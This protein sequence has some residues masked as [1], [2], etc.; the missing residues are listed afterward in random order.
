MP[1]SE[2]DFAIMC[3]G[4]NFRSDR[5]ECIRKLRNIENVNLQLLIVDEREKSESGRLHEKFSSLS[6][7]WINTSTKDAINKVAWYLQQ[8]FSGSPF[9]SV[10]LSDELN[11][12]KQIECGV[13]EDGFSEYFFKDDVDEIKSHN[14][15]FILRFG[16]GI[17]RGEILKVPNYGVWS[18]HHGDERKY[19]GGP[20]CFWEIYNDDPVTG[21]ILQRLTDRLDGGIIL[22]RGFFA[23][24]SSYANNKE[25]VNFGTTEWPAQVAIDILNGQAGYVNDPPTNSDAPI[26]RSPSPSQI[27]LY[28]LKRWKSL[29]AS[30]LSGINHWNIGIIQGCISNSLDGD[31]APE[32][33]WY[34]YPKNDGFLAD[35]FPI[36]IG[37]N[38][39]IFFEDYSYISKKGKISYIKYPEGF[40]KGNLKTA[41]EEPFHLSYPYL[42]KQDSVIYATPDNGD[43]KVVLY[44]VKKPSYWKKEKVLLEDDK[45]IS[46]PTIINYNST[47]WLFCTKHPYNNSKL[48]VYYSDELKGEWLPH[49]QNPVK[50]DVRSSRPGGTPFVN[51]NKLYRPAQCSSGEYGSK[52]AINYVRKLTPTQY[53]EEKVSEISPSESCSYDGMHTLSSQGD[54]TLIDRKKRIR[55]RYAL[56]QRA[57]QLISNFLSNHKFGTS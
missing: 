6:E 2:L 15:D 9:A 47:W 31:Y 19:R 32:I 25:N 48:Y 39:Y 34:S 16:F 57:N 44:E 33:N 23:T 30:A 54:I 55:N 42:F 53:I 27:L 35:P 17:I 3:S 43:N 20:S 52:I 38:K 8:H 36:N 50:T 13:R 28:N 46:D 11:S 5:V 26:Y 4:T 41:H 7:Y 45:G 24:K 18:F 21:S 10:D 29:G 56:Q 49:K 12:V 51:N 37:G 1:P 22:K 40:E 14:L